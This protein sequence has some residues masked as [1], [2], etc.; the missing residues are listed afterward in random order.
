[1]TTPTNTA[2]A[3]QTEATARRAL[4]EIMARHG[5]FVSSE[6]ADAFGKVN[7]GRFAPGVALED[8]YQRDRSVVTK[9]DEHGNP[10]STISAAWMQAT[11]LGQAR[12]EPGMRVLEIGSGGY[13]AALI[14]HLVGASGHVTTI[15]IDPWV[16]ERTR[17]FLGEDYPQITVLE[18]DAET[19]LPDAQPW[20]R[21]IVT[22]AAPDIPP[23][24]TNLVNGGR[25][26]VPLTVR[27]S[28]SWTVAFEWDGTHLAGADRHLCGFVPMQGL[29]AREPRLAFLDEPTVGLL[30]D[31]DQTVDIA[32]LRAALSGPRIELDSG[33]EIGGTE[34]FDDL[35]LWLA[36]QADVFASIRAEKPAI[37]SGLV[38]PSARWGAK[39]IISGGS[40]ACRF[41]KAVTPDRSLTS[42]AVYAHGPEAQRVG[43]QYVELIREWDQHHRHSHGPTLLVYPA[44][45]PTEQLPAGRVIAKKHTKTLISWPSRTSA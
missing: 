4:V 23:A 1:V 45:T 9:R 44:D 13:N 30:L 15:D 8:V 21:I 33:V 36:S 35:E 18:A 37:D 12:L 20:D 34:P 6:I 29:G 3:E 40:F 10:I 11:Q 7:R 42:F 5:D 26:A 41:S 28:L 32:A 2:A 39:T 27:G 25:L 19:A 31:D 22:V 24:W 38:A 17:E 14:A 16:V 43:T